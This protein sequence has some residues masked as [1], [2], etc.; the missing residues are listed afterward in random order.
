[1][2]NTLKGNLLVTCM[3]YSL[4]S[5]LKRNLSVFSLEI[6]MGGGGGFG[7]KGV[8]FVVVFISSVRSA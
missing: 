4:V 7:G 6:L 1:M 2:I 3:D 8:D 5:H